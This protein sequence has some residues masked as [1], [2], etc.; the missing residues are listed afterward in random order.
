MNYLLFREESERILFRKLEPSD[1]PTWL[2]F[3]KDPL[4][5]KYW[6]MSKQTP[7]AHCQQW[8][9]KVFN[10]YKNDLGGMN[11]LIDKKS[12][13][14]V[15]QCGLLIQ[16]VDGIEELEV[17]YSMMPQHRGKGYAPE[18]AKACIDFAFANQLS[19]SVISIIHEDNL[20]SQKV[21]LKNK[22]SL[23]KHTV[24]D[25]NPVKIYRI[26]KTMI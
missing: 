26:R 10:R 19:K 17:A 16:T 12:G 5:N 9:D 7:E 20:E 1:F 4:W 15:G 23:D 3:F 11:V 25:N 8:F 18:A 6:V 14:F 21:A 2:E 24:Y 13:A 22:L